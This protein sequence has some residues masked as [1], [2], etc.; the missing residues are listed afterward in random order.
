MLPLLIPRQ[1]IRSNA[2][3]VCI[4]FHAFVLHSLWSAP[5]DKTLI[6]SA[7]L[8]HHEELTDTISLNRTKRFRRAAIQR[9]AVED[10]V[11]QA[12]P[13]NE[14]SKTDFTT[15]MKGL[16]AGQGDNNNTEINDGLQLSLIHI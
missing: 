15:T 9:D 8:L 14:I 1:K 7:T 12:I 16:L 5:I 13:L 3:L 4:G 10:S 6:E 2:A 11:I